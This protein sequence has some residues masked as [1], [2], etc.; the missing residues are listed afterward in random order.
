MPGRRGPFTFPAKG[1]LPMPDDR[2]ESPPRRHEKYERLIEAARQMP[3]VTTAV[4][5]PCDD[6]SLEGAVEAARL[7]LIV[8][9]L[10]GPVERVRKTAEAASLD[11][12]SFELVDAAYSHELRDGFV[13]PQP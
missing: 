10:V 2:T 4:V 3:P 11:I 9:I 13:P 6:V 12:K 8:P 5:H 7:G 1:F